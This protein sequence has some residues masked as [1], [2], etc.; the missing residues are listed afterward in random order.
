M[1]RKEFLRAQLWIMLGYSKHTVGTR[2][3]SKPFEHLSRI[4][5]R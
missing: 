2:K 1:K 4:Q 5:G 3:A